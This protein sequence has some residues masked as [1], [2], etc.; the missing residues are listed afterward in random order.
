MGGKLHENTSATHPVT[1]S[2]CNVTFL[3]Y[4]SATITKKEIWI[5]GLLG[6]AL[7]QN[8]GKEVLIQQ[9]TTNC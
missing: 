8:L 9:C 5:H 7:L 6:S 4:S 2:L 1:T 3:I